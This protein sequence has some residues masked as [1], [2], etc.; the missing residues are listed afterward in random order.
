MFT[1]LTYSPKARALPLVVMLPLLFGLVWE[2]GAGMI[3]SWRGNVLVTKGDQQAGEEGSCEVAVGKTAGWQ[4][5][6]M[7]SMWII[8][9]IALMYLL[10]LIVAMAIFPIL[11][12]RL[13]AKERWL[14][15]LSV[16][17]GLAIGCYYLFVKF[18]EIPM[19]SGL[20]F[21]G[22]GF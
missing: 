10:G 21:K 13:H 16:A 18:L 5:E 14:T 7:A 19:F 22:L 2:L 6:V 3:S 1:A 20:V 9:M 8:A 15:T 17:L 4:S 12:M 11:Y